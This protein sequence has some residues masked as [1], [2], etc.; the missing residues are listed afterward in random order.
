MITRL[1][2][3]LSDLSAFNLK[4]APWWWFQKHWGD[5]VGNGSPNFTRVDVN[6]YVFYIFSI[7]KFIPKVIHKSLTLMFVK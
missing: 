4:R 6:V 2:T 3:N 5:E 7:K 1:F